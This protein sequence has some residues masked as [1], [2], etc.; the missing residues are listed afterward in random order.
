MRCVLCYKNIAGN[1]LARFCVFSTSILLSLLSTQAQLSIIP[2]DELLAAEKMV[3]S[4][5]WRLLD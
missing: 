4:S 3:N 5:R 2:Q 1:K